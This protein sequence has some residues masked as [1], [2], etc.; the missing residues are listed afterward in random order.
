MNPIVE[1]RT[2]LEKAG[3]KPDFSKK[4][5]ESLEIYKS[6]IQET[7]EADFIS[8]VTKAKKIC[9]EETESFKRDLARRVQI[10]CETK[11]SAIETQM[12]KQSVRNES[13]S[14]SK[15]TKIASL[16]E[17]IELNAKD[18][19]KLRE[20]VRSA[21]VRIR[22]LSESKDKTAELANRQTAIARKLLS[23]S[24]DLETENMRLKKMLSVQTLN[25]QRTTAPRRIG[26]LPRNRVTQNVH[27]TR[28]TLVESQD[29]ISPP[30]QAAI[31][32]KGGY[33][34]NSIAADLDETL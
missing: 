28:P 29:P 4:I 30:R 15:L 16:V 17:G 13:M 32:V 5:V 7:L 27:T 26:M 6:N 18:D 22:E 2:L 21:T 8:K 1:L 31:A 14:S 20:Q 19:G 9:V 33:N 23:E 24:K 10:F 25:E 34:I 12:R 3:V 11:G